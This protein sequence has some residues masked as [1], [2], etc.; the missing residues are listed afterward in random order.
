[1]EVIYIC[2]VTGK[3]VIGTADALPKE[4]MVPEMDVSVDEHR[5]V[6]P[7]GTVIALSSREA[8]EKFLQKRIVS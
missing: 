5:E 3:R 8:W 6:L 7:H 1:M 2:A 4:W